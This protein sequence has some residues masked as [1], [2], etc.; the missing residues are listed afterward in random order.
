MVNLI[1]SLLETVLTKVGVERA[2]SP[3]PSP[4]PAPRTPTPPPPPPAPKR[5]EETIEVDIRRRGPHG[6]F[7]EDIKI[8]HDVRGRTDHETALV[9]HRSHS[10][11]SAPRHRSASAAP[12]RRF[13]D[14]DL[15]EEADY[16][17]RRQMERAYVGEAHNGATK[18]WAIVDVPPGTERVKMDGAGGSSQE[19]TWQRYNGVRRAKFLAGEREFKTGFGMP[20]RKP[21]PAPAPAPLPPPAPAPRPRASSTLR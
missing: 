3:E 9:H 1:R 4:P 11:H 21:S 6:D 12:R 19:V 15:E 8:E 20:E 17:N 13:Y 7:E 16:Y 14:D 10:S 2:W 5:V 18:D